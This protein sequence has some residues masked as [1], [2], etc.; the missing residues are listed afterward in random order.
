MHGAQETIE[1]SQRCEAP[2]HAAQGYAAVPISR[3]LEAMAGK[4]NCEDCGE[5]VIGRRKLCWHCGK[6]VC[7]WCWGH[8]HQCE[9]GHSKKECRDFQ[10]YK[11]HGKQW[12]ARLR[13]RGEIVHGKPH[14]AAGELRLPDSDARKETR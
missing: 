6:Y 11:R 4:H 14:N 8:V 9:P 3:V 7:G 5:R 2:L 12:I 1:S 10:R 13:A